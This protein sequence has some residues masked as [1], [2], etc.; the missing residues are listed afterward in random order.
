MDPNAVIVLDPVNRRVIDSALAKGVKD[1]IG[2]NCTVSLM[3]MAIQGLFDKGWVSGEL[4]DLSSRLGRAPRTC[5]SEQ[6]GRT[7]KGSSSTTIHA[8]HG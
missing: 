8:W 6:E 2:G 3:L 5:A 1:C 7:A 4:D